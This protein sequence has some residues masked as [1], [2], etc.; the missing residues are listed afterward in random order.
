MTATTTRAKTLWFAVEIVSSHA[1]ST[2][3]EMAREAVRVALAE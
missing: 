3:P 2:Y 1:R